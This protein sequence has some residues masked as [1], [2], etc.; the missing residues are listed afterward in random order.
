ALVGELV[1]VPIVYPD[2]LRELELT[3]QA[4]AKDEGGDT[5]IHSVIWHAFRQRRT[6]CRP[7]TDHAAAVH[8][9]RGVSRVQAPHVRT[10][11]DG[12]AVRVHFAVVEIVVALRVRAKH[13]IVPLGR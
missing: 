3:N 5:A 1:E 4:R 9:C 13:W 2:V 8:V 6:V 11:W 7:A 10:E 12:V